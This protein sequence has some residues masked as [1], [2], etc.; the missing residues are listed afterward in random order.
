[1]LNIRHACVKTHWKK[2]EFSNVPAIRATQIARKRAERCP[3]CTARKTA[4]AVA[5]AM[6]NQPRR[7]DLRPAA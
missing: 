2:Y 7:S 6:L 3:N 5:K 1:M 4:L